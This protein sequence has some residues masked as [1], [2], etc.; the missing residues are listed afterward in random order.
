MSDT[1]KGSSKKRLI[2]IL[3]AAVV[4]GIGIT[5][6]ALYGVGMMGGSSHAAHADSGHGHDAH[7]TEHSGATR[8]VDL[9]E[10]AVTAYQPDSGATLLIS[11]HL[12]GT[13]P[14][15]AEES[16]GE[17]FETNKHRARQHVLVSV[18]NAEMA[19]L[20]DPGLGLIRRQVKHHLNSTFGKPVLDEIVFSDFLITER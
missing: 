5:A 6:G 20:M 14:H 13:I 9:G 4:G 17:L 8:E 16:F 7:A 10:Y 3:V 15:E 18:R 11:F 12:Y 19:D 1:A 2:I